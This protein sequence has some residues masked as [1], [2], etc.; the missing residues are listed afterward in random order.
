MLRTLATLLKKGWPFLSAAVLTV[1][2]IVAYNMGEILE[3]H[4]RKLMENVHYAIAALILFVSFYF[5]AL[6]IRT[7]WTTVHDEDD[8]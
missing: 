6:L 1:L 2:V 5:I 8:Q 4:H 3:K 7:V